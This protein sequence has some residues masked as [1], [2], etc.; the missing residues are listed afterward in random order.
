M[1]GRDK[2]ANESFMSTSEIGH[3]DGL[4]PVHQS[5]ASPNDRGKPAVQRGWGWDGG[6]LGAGGWLIREH[7]Y[8][9]LRAWSS[10]TVRTSHFFLNHFMLNLSLPSTTPGFPSLRT[11]A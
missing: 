1:L 6:G 8:A 5:H 10:S 11:N 7:C 2:V 9:R 3:G 4:Q